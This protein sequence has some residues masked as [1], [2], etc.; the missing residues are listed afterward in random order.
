M[1]L[2][3]VNIFRT[4]TGPHQGCGASL[5]LA[6][7]LAEIVLYALPGKDRAVLFSQRWVVPLV[8]KGRL[9]EAV[10]KTCLAHAQRPVWFASRCR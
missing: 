6:W 10:L 1:Q 3:T 5:Q 2:E 4:S 8:I 9:T 7:E